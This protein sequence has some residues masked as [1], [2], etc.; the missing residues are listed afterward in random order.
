MNMQG[1]NSAGA[2][3]V[4][5]NKVDCAGYCNG[6]ASYDDC[7]VCSGGNSGHTSNS[8][9]DACGICFGN[10]T[11]APTPVCDTSLYVDIVFINTYSTHICGYFPNILTIC[12][13]HVYVFQMT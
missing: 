8:D 5:C 7:G 3:L 2:Y 9:I 6:R 13:L 12:L 10:N 11:C 1:L 4:C